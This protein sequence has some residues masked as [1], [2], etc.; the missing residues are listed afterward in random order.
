MTVPT[1]L[2]PDFYASANV[3]LPAMSAFG[4]QAGLRRT[5]SV[6]SAGSGRIPPQVPPKIQQSP[7]RQNFTGNSQLGTGLD[8]WDVTPQDKA[9]F[10]NLF[11]GID[12]SNKGFVEGTTMRVK[13][14]ALMISLG[15]EAVAFFLTS[16]LSDELLAH[17]WDL[18][19]IQKQGKLNRDTF[20]VAM[21]LIR[22][23]MAGKDLPASLPAS[24]VPPSLR[25]QVSAP[26]S[27]SPPLQ[28]LQPSSAT[29]DLFGLDNIFGLSSTT[30]Q[31]GSPGSAFQTLPPSSP[32]RTMTPQKATSS[33]KPVSPVISTPL[34]RQFQPTSDFGRGLSTPP[35]QSPVPKTSFPP[36]ITVP[37]FNSA[38]APVQVPMQ[39]GS[40]FGDQAPD[41]L[42]DADPEINQKL[43]AE[44]AELANLSNQIGSLNTATRGLQGNKARAETELASVTQQKRDIEA[45]LKQI[46]SLYDA[47]VANVRAVEE[48][49]TK[50]RGELTENRREVTVLE[51][52]LSALQTQ[53]SEQKFMLQKDQAENSS[54]KARISAVGEE[55]KTLKETLEKVKRDARQQRGMVAI[56]KKQLSTMEGER[57]KIQGEIGVEQKELEALEAEHA[58][59]QQQPVPPVVSREA[60][61]APVGSERSTGTNPFLR[62]HTM[63]D[64]T[65]TFSPPATSFF[66]AAQTVSPAPISSPPAAQ[67]VAAFDDSTFATAFQDAF[68]AAQ[69]PAPASPPE[70]TIHQPTLIIPPANEPALNQKSPPSI[71]S[72]LSP[73]LAARD[74][75]EYAESATSSL[76]VQAPRSVVASTNGDILASSADITPKEEKEASTEA[77]GVIST[78]T[79]PET[80]P[81]QARDGV[82][83][84]DAQETGVQGSDKEEAETPQPA[85]AGPVEHTI[86][87]T[88]THGPRAA[89]PLTSPDMV[90]ETLSH[91]P[92]DEDLIISSPPPEAAPEHPPKPAEFEDYPKTVS[93]PGESSDEGRESWVDLG[94]ESKNFPSEQLPAPSTEGLASN[95]SDPFAFSTSAP[96]VPVRQATKEDF[97]AAFSTFGNFGK[98]D[99]ESFGVGRDFDSEF[100][101]IEEYVGDESQSDEETGFNDNFTESSKPAIRSNGKLAEKAP[102]PPAKEVLPTIITPE[103]SSDAPPP[104]PPKDVSTLPPVTPTGSPLG[105]EKEPPPYSGGYVN[106]AETSAGSNDLS[107][108]LPRRG[109]PHLSDAPYTSPPPPEGFSTPTPFPPVQ[110]VSISPPLPP[111]MSNGV[112]TTATL[113][114]VPEP[115]PK[116]EPPIQEPPQITFPR[117]QTPSKAAE[118]QV[119]SVPET[120]VPVQ[121]ASEPK[122]SPPTQTFA[123]FDF[124]G[125]Q[126][127]APLDESHD[128]PFMLSNQNHAFGEFDTSFDSTPVTPAKPALTSTQQTPQAPLNASFGGTP[129]QSTADTNNNFNLFNWDVEFD[130]LSRTT[131]PSATQSNATATSNFDDVF[132]SFDKPVNIQPPALP[133]R[134]ESPDD[135]P[136]LKTLT[137]VAFVE[138]D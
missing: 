9:A 29:Q 119:S 92:R 110:P 98:K 72:A 36:T 67:T 86:I 68:P 99:V 132:A 35:V 39:S 10:D 134:K 77:A 76:A 126:E 5:E 106:L 50:V 3:S 69:S 133:P 127:S 42:G 116:E 37:Q 66:P 104:V 38:P 20:A 74:D 26:A 2:P 12:T 11:K 95:R 102:S 71:S 40:V 14:V 80:L 24:L 81:P 62:M 22:Q 125:L 138:C 82:L 78:L 28:T 16:K 32:P 115:P 121:S 19:D 113:P 44:T 87:T 88:P 59:Q 97:D 41:L 108:L 4:G 52:S 94:D 58:A 120:S 27:Q 31:P 56:N 96:S 13:D 53:F 124:S 23:K 136:D 118:P 117:L 17:I 70:P 64:R 48:Q 114:S 61:M 75:S 55:M 131:G 43:T 73:P 60:V 65:G 123:A 6:S 45:R 103:A 51:A 30:A 8:G 46:R 101:P 15:N 111:K 54:L 84:S 137:G 90:Q 89:T 57:E 34:Q 105:G 130:S 49:L 33:P 112:S 83:T 93:I 47:E 129:A 107:G 21:H 135:I 18:A 85:P 63:G 79:S 122:M 7:V 109:E 91:P 1:A 25:Q 128:D 100:P